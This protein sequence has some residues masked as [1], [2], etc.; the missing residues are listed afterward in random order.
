MKYRTQD[1]YRDRY[2]TLLSS[3]EDGRYRSRENTFWSQ[4]HDGTCMTLTKDGYRRPDQSH[5]D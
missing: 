4:S 5:H 3:H 1:E 2:C